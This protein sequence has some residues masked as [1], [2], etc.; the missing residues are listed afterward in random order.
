MTA[1]VLSAPRRRF[2]KP[3]VG[4]GWPVVVAAGFLFLVALMAILAPVIAPHDPSSTDLSAVFANPSAAHPLGTDSLGRDTASRLIWAARASIVAPLV[5]VLI[6]ATLGL[7]LALVA[8]WWGGRVDS[9]V[10]GALDIVLGFPGLL[11]AVLAVS[12][13][14]VG[15]VAPTV[16]L[17]IA[18]TAYFARLT[19]AIARRERSRTYVTALSQQGFGGLRIALRHVSP[20]ILPL[21][22]AQAA[23]LFGYA[24]VDLAAISYLGMGV[25][26]PTPDWGSMVALGQE[27]LLGGHPLPALLAGAMVVLTVIAV[28]L[29]A[30]R[31][32]DKVSGGSR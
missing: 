27:D 2:L 28:N 23:I 8:A 15:I 14:G 21:V 12:L 22:V 20:N 18:Y 17:S 6:A 30:E 10:S 32:A 16:A 9:F 25:Q 24:M 13:F 31:M 1:D 3:L 19:R 5:V 29:I 11:L 4:L 7:L 26:P